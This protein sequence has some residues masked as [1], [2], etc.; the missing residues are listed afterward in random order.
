MQAQASLAGTAG[1]DLPDEDDDGQRVEDGH[2][3]AG[4]LQR[5][6][7]GAGGSLIAHASGII[8]GIV[9]IR[10]HSKNIIIGN[11]GITSYL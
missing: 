2:R 8:P 11:F 7:G 1:S 6:Q 4:N 5:G 10:V 3:S 9:I